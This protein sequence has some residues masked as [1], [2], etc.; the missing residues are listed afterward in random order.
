MPSAAS[1]LVTGINV[2]RVTVRFD[3]N[4]YHSTLSGTRSKPAFCRHPKAHLVTTR[5]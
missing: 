3:A 1:Y 5:G 4:D 2:T